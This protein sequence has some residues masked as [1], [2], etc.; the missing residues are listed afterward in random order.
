MRDNGKA[1]KEAMLSVI[2]DIGDYNDI[3]KQELEAIMT[4]IDAL[5]TIWKDDK[6]NQFI[7]HVSDMRSSLLDELTI[8]ENAR[9][10]L[11]TKVDLM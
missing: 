3:V 10:Q 5:S 1:T 2:K 11:Q 4:E 8:L 6:Y 9:H 7:E